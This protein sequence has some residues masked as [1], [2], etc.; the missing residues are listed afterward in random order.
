MSQNVL[1]DIPSEPV[2]PPQWPAHPPKKMVMGPLMVTV[3]GLLAFFAVVL[4]VVF[5][6]TTT[7]EPEPS[8][9]WRPH[10]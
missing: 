7:F 9:N 6:P 2:H 8:E 10:G 1:P 5:L 3:G 4:M